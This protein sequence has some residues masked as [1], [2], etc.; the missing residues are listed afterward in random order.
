M[1][2]S[3]GADAKRLARCGA[4]R[5]ERVAELLNVIV[6]DHDACLGRE[7]HEVGV[8]LAV[9]DLLKDPRRGARTVLDVD[10]QDVPLPSRDLVDPS[11]G[12]RGWRGSVRGAHGAGLVCKDATETSFTRGF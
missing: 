5:L 12:T 1:G 11:R 7:V 9:G 8:Q 6:A 10:E 3:E 4:E 2:R